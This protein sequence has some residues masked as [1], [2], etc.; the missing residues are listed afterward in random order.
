LNVDYLDTFATPE[1]GLKNMFGDG[2]A[3][4]TGFDL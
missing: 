2:A 3:G 1:E 4:S